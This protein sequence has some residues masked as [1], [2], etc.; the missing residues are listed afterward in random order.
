MG[1]SG[2]RA[3]ACPN[4]FFWWFLGKGRLVAPVPPVERTM[5]LPT[6]P[7]WDAGERCVWFEIA[8]KAHTILCRID[9]LTFVNS[10]GATSVSEGA[11]RSALKSQWKRIHAAALSQAEASHFE[12]TPNL[13]RRFVWLTDKSF[14]PRQLN[15][16]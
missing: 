9:A 10:L 7:E 3:F 15:I 2:F 5:A 12:S 14:A 4:E 13:V 16:A 8:Y 6:P 11:C 1:S